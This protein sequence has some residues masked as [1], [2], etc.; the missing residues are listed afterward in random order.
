MYID[1]KPFYRLFPASYKVKVARSLSPINIHLGTMKRLNFSK[2]TAE[3]AFVVN[4]SYSEGYGHIINQARASGSVVVT[5]DV[6]PLNEL[7]TANETGVL[8]PVHRQ[9]HPMVMLGGKYRGP[10]GLEGVEGM[11]AS[12]ESSEVCSTVKRLVQ[13][14]TP[15]ERAAMGFNARRQYHA[16]TKYFASA[17][18]ELRKFAKKKNN[19]VFIPS[20][21]RMNVE[22]F[23]TK[24]KIPSKYRYFETPIGLSELWLSSR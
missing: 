19:S 2:L 7:I 5:T 24:Q 11:V 8:I 1:R 21:K 18:E 20:I 9:K 3:A 22:T 6:P 12:F 4:P 14:T 10:H 13:S 15:A 16:D 23:I 17:M